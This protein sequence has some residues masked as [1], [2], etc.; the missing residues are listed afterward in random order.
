MNIET[1]KSYFR[2]DGEVTGILDFA[3]EIYGRK[4]FHDPK[5]NQYYYS[6]GMPFE[7]V[8]L[9]SPLVLENTPPKEKIGMKD[10]ILEEG[11]RYLRRDGKI[12][13]PLRKDQTCVLY[14]PKYKI[15]YYT[16]G[17][18]RMNNPGYDIVDIAHCKWVYRTND[19]S[20]G[21]GEV[22]NKYDA[23]LGFK[24]CPY[25]GLTIK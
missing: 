2:G 18:S 8:P 6:N 4:I 3:F 1:G 9:L 23:T 21:C 13:D 14:D 10:F 24:H 19:I 15:G 7:H 17:K 25:C 12:T 22:I 20:T 16:R 11:G 5:M